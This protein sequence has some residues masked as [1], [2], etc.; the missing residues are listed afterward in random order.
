[1]P[2]ECWDAALETC[3]RAAGLFPGCLCVG[4]DLLFT[5]SYRR[6]AVLEANAFGDLLPG[7]VWNGLDPYEAELAALE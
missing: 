1:V 5:P 6:H 2:V 3:R 4:V 7:A